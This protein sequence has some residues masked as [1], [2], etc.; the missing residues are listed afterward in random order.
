MR[1]SVVVVVVQAWMM[2]SSPFNVRSSRDRDS[3]AQIAPFLQLPD[4]CNLICCDS[5]CLRLEKRWWYLGHIRCSQQIVYVNPLPRTNCKT[6]FFGSLAFHTCTFKKWR[7]G[8]GGCLVL[9]LS[10]ISDWRLKPSIR[11]GALITT[12]KKTGRLIG[13][14]PS[15][16]SCATENTIIQSW[17]TWRFWTTFTFMASALASSYPFKPL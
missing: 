11:C 15:V 16:C 1:I 8:E 5:S 13:S 9:Y 7:G 3:W 4:S 2:L 12:S 17:S 10:V 14:N 6:Y